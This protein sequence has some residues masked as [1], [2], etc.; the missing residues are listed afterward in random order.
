MD[1]IRTKL[2]RLVFPIDFVI[3]IAILLSDIS[4]VGIIPKNILSGSME[5]TFSI[6]DT[7]YIDKNVDFQNIKEG[8]VIAYQ[9]DGNVYV[10]H[11]VVK[12]EKEQLITKGDSNESADAT[13][14]TQVSYFG[15]VMFSLPYGSYIYVFLNSW[16]FK[17]L[18][19]VLVGITFWCI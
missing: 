3:V 15:K 9:T 4:I 7:V 8:D 19:I 13:P 18:I 17:I 12:T 5:P 14:V 10:V 6:G 16:F 1:A 2:A 11:R